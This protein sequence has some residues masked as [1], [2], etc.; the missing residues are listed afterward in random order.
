MD[1][2]TPEK[3]ASSICQFLIPLRSEAHLNHNIAT[4]MLSYTA[5]HPRRK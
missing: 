3:P 4:Y 5:S 2:N 1:T